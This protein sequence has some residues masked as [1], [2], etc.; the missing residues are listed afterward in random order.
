MDLLSGVR[1]LPDVDELISVIMRQKK[2]KRVHIIELFLDDE[3]K[4]AVWEH[5][6]L[7][8]GLNQRDPFYNLKKQIKIHEFLGYDVFRVDIIHKDF[9]KM[10]FVT[11]EDTTHLSFCGKQSCPGTV[12][13]QRLHTARAGPTFF[14]TAV[15]SRVLWKIS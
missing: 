10:A 14:T 6:D 7:A 2:P 12:A 3:V 5:F 8:A 13:V 15:T 9:F 1:V 4:E 11:T